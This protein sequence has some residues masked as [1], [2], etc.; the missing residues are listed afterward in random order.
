MASDFKQIP[1]NPLD[2]LMIANAR[3][4]DFQKQHDR[5]INTTVG[6]LVDPDT[7]KIWRPRAVTQALQD[8]LHTISDNA[9]YGYQPQ[10][11]NALF[12]DQAAKLVFG[13][14]P[15]RDVLAYQTLGGTGALSL[16]KDVLID[17]HPPQKD[18][19][20]PLV[21]DSGWPNHPAIF[22]EPFVIMSYP[23]LNESGAYNHQAALQAIA[24]APDKS[25]ILLQV[26][27]YND[28]GA[29]RSHQQWDEILDAAAVKKAT[30]VLDA[31]YLGLADGFDQDRY[32]IVRCVEKGLL[33]FVCVS[34][35]KN[36][37]LYNERLGALFMV[38]AAQHLG[39]EQTS[40]LNKL[41]ARIVRRTIGLGAPLLASEAAFLALELTDYYDE[42]EKMRVRLNKHRQIFAN[43]VGEA[44]PYVATGRGLF[45][46]LLPTGF[47]DA[48]LAFLESQGILAL[49]NSR[50]N[51]GGLQS[52]QVEPVAT[53]MRQAL[54]RQ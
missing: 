41:M 39:E 10:I 29:D 43:I 22:S 24:E 25:I 48:Q 37:G 9:R 8:A 16:L 6:I 14:T 38:N 53:V 51:L 52:S 11:G 12:L 50:V 20:L 32:P 5:A 28:D 31:A 2:P 35:S 3:W 19:I 36:M 18:S 27:G 13:H 23:H 34:M 15:L 42:L 1:A 30:V 26:C 7:G 40:S 47:S 49:Q 44:A 45:T 33:T 21:L 17:L 54:E 46:K 4:P